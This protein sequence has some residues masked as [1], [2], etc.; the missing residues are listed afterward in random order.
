LTATIE[1]LK[2][3]TLSL[4]AGSTG[5]QSEKFN[6][7]AAPVDFQFIYGVASDGLCPFEA[8]LHDKAIGDSLSLAVSSGEAHEFFGHLFSPLYR[9]L[10]VQIIPETIT[11]QAEI[12]SV[13][14]A[15]N[16]EIVQS[17]AKALASGGCGGS[18]G[19]GC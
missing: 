6:L 1:P 10:G 14:A 4:L 17:L 13:A 15:E 7:T 19:C 2:K 18:C 5:S 8:A 9:A 3:V 16:Q 12:T 11:L